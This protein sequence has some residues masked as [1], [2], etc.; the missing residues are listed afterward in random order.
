MSLV[1]NQ[2]V[3]ANSGGGWWIICQARVLLR[4]YLAT[5]FVILVLYGPCIAGLSIL[6]IHT[7]TAE[8][9]RCVRIASTVSA[10]DF[11]TTTHE[12]VALR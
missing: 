5:G 4:R 10:G 11:C 1:Q 12:P 7:L 2:P 3:Y 8:Q 9:N 6:C